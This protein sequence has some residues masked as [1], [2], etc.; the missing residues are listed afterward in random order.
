MKRSPLKSFLSGFGSFDPIGNGKPF[1]KALQAFCKAVPIWV[2]LA[3]LGDLPE[4][5]HLLPSLATRGG[6]L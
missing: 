1:C 4:V 6:I 2:S 3:N 5:S